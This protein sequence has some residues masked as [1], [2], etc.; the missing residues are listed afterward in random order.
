M[1]AFQPCRVDLIRLPHNHSGDL[2]REVNLSG[3]T[4]RAAS[5]FIR[6]LVVSQFDVEAA[7]CR[8]NMAG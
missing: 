6:R 3:G 7:L 4:R 1:T 8:H 5:H 2:G